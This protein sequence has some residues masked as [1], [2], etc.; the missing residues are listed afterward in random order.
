MSILTDASLDPVTSEFLLDLSENCML[1]TG[2]EN[3]FNWKELGIV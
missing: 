2:L 3:Y 1:E